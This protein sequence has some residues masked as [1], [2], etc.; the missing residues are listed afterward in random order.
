MT[1]SNEITD[2]EFGEQIDFKPR[3]N[4]L[5]FVDDIMMDQLD[6]NIFA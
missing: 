2:S 1:P 5:E 6:H 3:N 4:W